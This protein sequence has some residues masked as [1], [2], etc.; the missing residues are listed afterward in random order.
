MSFSFKSSNITEVSSRGSSLVVV[1][2]E[3]SVELWEVQ[4]ATNPVHPPTAGGFQATLMLV[5][6][7]LAVK[8]WTFSGSKKKRTDVV[9]SRMLNNYAFN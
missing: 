5:W 4:V 6:A 9:T 7:T 8:S 2:E 3:V 1:A